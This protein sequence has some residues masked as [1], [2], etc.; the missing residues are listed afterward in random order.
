MH[1]IMTQGEE[2]YQG[3]DSPIKAFAVTDNQPI[4]SEQREPKRSR[5][6][7]RSVKVRQGLEIEVVSDRSEDM[8]RKK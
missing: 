3:S 8:K 5:G 6:S 4:D 7:K 2:T 1:E